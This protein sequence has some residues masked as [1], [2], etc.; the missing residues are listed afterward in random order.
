MKTQTNGLL[1]LALSVL[2]ACN[3]TPK[4][5]APVAAEPVNNMGVFNNN[6]NHQHEDEVGDA[7]HSVVVKE[8]L[9]AE[10]YSYLLVTHGDKEM[11]VATMKAP[12]TP[13]ESYKMKTGLLK[14]NFKSIEHNRTFAEI[15]LV[16]EIYPETAQAQ[17]AATRDEIDEL[18]P[19]AAVPEGVTRLADIINAPQ[20]Y[21]GK[22]VRIYGKVLKVNPNIMERNWMH[23]DDGSAP[24]YDFVLTTQN[25]IP[26]GH[27]VA[28]EGT[29]ALNKDFGAG[30][31]YEI[32]MENAKLV[33]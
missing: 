8:V 32:I 30:Y 10:R 15:Y 28:F 1:I 17:S 9:Q 13:G 33:K 18:Q 4:E 29:I 27:E 3:S 21:A 24:D 11:W 2:A 19:A 7:L 14:T 12:Y 5:I 31:T 23:I 20:D 25:Q 26:V 22:S 6:H 16:S